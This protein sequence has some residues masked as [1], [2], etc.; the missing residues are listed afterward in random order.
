MS[1]GTIIQKHSVEEDAP[2]LRAKVPA[3]GLTPACRYSLDVSSC[4]LSLKRGQQN[5]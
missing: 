2:K 1:Q 5:E 4:I 3:N